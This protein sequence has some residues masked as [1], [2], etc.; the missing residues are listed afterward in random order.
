VSYSNRFIN[1]SARDESSI[2]YENLTVILQGA[3]SPRTADIIS[4]WRASA[5]GCEIVLSS[6]AKDPELAKLVDKYLIN[7]DPGVF[8]VMHKGEIL[9]AENINRQIVSSVAGLRSTT[10]R[11]SIKWRTDFDFCST[12]MSKFLS[13]YFPLISE[14]EEKKLI[15]FSIN[16]INP[17]SGA[18]MVAHLSDWMYF[19]R[20]DLLLSLLPTAPIPAILENFEVPSRVIA[21]KM[22]P[23]ARFSV[24]Q[25]MLRDGFARVYGLKINTFDDTNA[26]APYLQLIGKKILIINPRVV[27][28]ATVKYDYL[29]NPQLRTLREFIGFRLST[30]SQ[31]D[32]ILLGIV[33][34][35]PFA[36]GILKCKGWIFNFYK[37]VI[38]RLR[39]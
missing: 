36:V 32:S 5:K 24:E 23:I 28:L 34:L 6:W 8:P 21:E 31:F 9:R 10:R 37:F 22:F 2:M 13:H 33:I 11:I 3:L 39:S 35:R 19:G 29:F 15:V 25:W 30:I 26:I 14:S 4:N 7:S 38:A 18:G 12:L 1:A 16:S 20:T 17:F 27:G